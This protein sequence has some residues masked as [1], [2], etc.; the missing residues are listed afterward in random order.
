MGWTYE[1]VSC[2]S[3]SRSAPRFFVPGTVEFASMRI[4]AMSTECTLGQSSSPL[5]RISPDAYIATADILGWSIQRTGRRTT[6]IFEVEVTLVTCQL[7]ERWRINR[8][9]SQFANLGMFLGQL[10]VLFLPPPNPVKLTLQ[11]RDCSA[12][13]RSPTTKFVHL[14]SQRK[15]QLTWRAAK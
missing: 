2:E 8:R 11:V 6:A 3:N 13:S 5:D 15:S 14:T 7:V 12:G 4:I 9:F 10:Q 1:S